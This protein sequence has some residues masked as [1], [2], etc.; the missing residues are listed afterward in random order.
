MPNR[1]LGEGVSGHCLSGPCSKCGQAKVFPEPLRSAMGLRAIPVLVVL[2][3]LIYWMV[4]MRWKQNST[5]VTALSSDV[6]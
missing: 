4:P 3:F 6:R 2:A 1:S 5:V